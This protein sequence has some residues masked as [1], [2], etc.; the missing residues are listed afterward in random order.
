MS[1]EC[2]ER[3]GCSNAC[4]AWTCMCRSQ[5][6]GEVSRGGAGLGWSPV[7]CPTSCAQSRRGFPF[8][9]PLRLCIISGAPFWLSIFG[10]PFCLALCFGSPEMEGRTKWSAQ[11]ESKMESL[12]KGR[13]NGHQ[14]W[15]AKIKMETFDLVGHVFV[16]SPRAALKKL[17][18]GPLRF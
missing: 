15:R 9:P 16:V 14:K 11:M 5:A 10:S 13:Q 4:V 7:C 1:L 6:S 3:T 17:F 18:Q 2:C 12:N 8:W